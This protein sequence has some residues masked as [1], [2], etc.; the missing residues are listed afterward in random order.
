LR[1]PGISEGYKALVEANNPKEK[2]I[3]KTLNVS[4]LIEVENKEFVS[5][6]VLGYLEGGDKKDELVII[7]AHYDH[8]GKRGEVIYNGADDDGSGTAAIL[9][10]AQAFAQAKK[11]ENG[12]RRSV[13]FLAF[14]GEEKGLLGSEYY[15]NNP[16]FPLK[17]VIADLNIDMIGRIDQRHAP[18]SNYVYIIG[19]DKL[20]SELHQ[21]NDKANT[22][23]TQLELDYT[24]N[25][26]NDPNRF[27]YRSDHY[28]FAKNGVPVI[29]YFTG[30]HKDYHRPSDTIEKIMFGKTEKITRLIFHTAW[31]LANREERIKLDAPQNKE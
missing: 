5:E 3:L 28:N 15:S 30:V 26:E 9:E 23:Y 31:E 25:D 16:V 8:L 10:M 6:N 24:Y 21:I 19:S 22:T 18:D 14:S 7:S 29:F 20:S 27:Y 1:K 12:P 4:V 2:P 17:S 11:E 13:L